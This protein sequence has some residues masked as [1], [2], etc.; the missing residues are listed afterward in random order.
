[1]PKPLR[2]VLLFQLLIYNVIYVKG[3]DYVR[4]IDSA[5][6]TTCD[7]TISYKGF[8]LRFKATM[9][10]QDISKDYFYERIELFPSSANELNKYRRCS[11]NMVVSELLA[12]GLGVLSAVTYNPDT[13]KTI[14]I[15]AGALAIGGVGSASF[16]YFLGRQHLRNAVSLYNKEILKR[17]HT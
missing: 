3:Q 13:V 4:P 14:P 2:T 6:C 9:N 10:K 8:G 16:C 11:K 15:L 7:S 5:N 1:M 17:K 12:V